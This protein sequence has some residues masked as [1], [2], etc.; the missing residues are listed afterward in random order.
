MTR[1]DSIIKGGGGGLEPIPGQLQVMSNKLTIILVNLAG[2]VCEVAH[3]FD[4]GLAE[5]VMRITVLKSIFEIN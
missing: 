5:T 1:K 4:Y 3:R 2:K